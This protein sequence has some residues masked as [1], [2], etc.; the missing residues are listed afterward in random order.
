[1]APRKTPAGAASAWYSPALVSPNVTEKNRAITH[2]IAATQINEMGDTALRLGS[3]R[4][5]DKGS[6]FYP[7]FMSAVIAGLV[8]PFSEFFLAV[9]RQYQL[10]TPHIHSNSILLMSIFA[11]YYE[12]HVGVVPSVALP[13]HFFSLRVSSGNISACASFVAYSKSNAIS[14]VGK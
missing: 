2:Q 6:T 8:P 5:V 9:L 10:H 1:M 13:H 12:A 11:Y 4:P 3:S 7:L 14:K